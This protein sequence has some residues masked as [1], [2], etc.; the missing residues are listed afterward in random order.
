MIG[1]KKLHVD[2]ILP[3]YATAGAAAFDL[4]AAISV[5]VYPGSAVTVSTGLAVK[6]P[7]GLAML[8]YSRSGHGFK[9]GLR[10]G[11]AVGLVDSDYRGEVLVRVHNDGTEPYKIA[12][13]E[14]IAQAMI[15]EAQQ[16]PLMWVDD[17]G[18][19]ARGE[20]GFGSTGK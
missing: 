8:V 2:A 11:N 18:S 6:L 19:S 9:H 12:R 5:I 20:N 17:V 16:Y 10:L 13:G 7:D 15:V 14:R 4:S 1:F 3:T